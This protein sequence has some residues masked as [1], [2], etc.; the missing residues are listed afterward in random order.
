MARI[1]IEDVSEYAKR[2][3]GVLYWQGG[4]WGAEWATAVVYGSVEAAQAQL[5]IFDEGR[6]AY[7]S[8]L[9]MPNP[10]PSYVARLVDLDKLQA[11]NRIWGEVFRASLAAGLGRPEASGVAKVAIRAAGLDDITAR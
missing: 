10:G 8:R 11:A 7:Y 5:A 6:A 2:E 4:A 9:R 1:I 3:H